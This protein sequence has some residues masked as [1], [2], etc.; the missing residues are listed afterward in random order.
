[1]LLVWR[2]VSQEV[3]LSAF[4]CHVAAAVLFVLGCLFLYWTFALARLRYVIDRNALTVHWG[5]VR[6]VVPM[7]KIERVITGQTTAAPQIAGVNWPG[8][9]VGSGSV[10]LIGESLF[11]SAHSGPGDLAYIV[12]PEQTYALSV[13]NA[14][15][16]RKAMEA[17]MR[18]GPEI[19]MRQV[20]RRSGLAAQPFWE[21]KL[22]KGLALLGVVLRDVRRDCHATRTCAEPRGL[23]AATCAWP[24]RASS[25]AALYGDRVLANLV[26]GP[27]QLGEDDRPPA[28]HRTCGLR[29][30]FV[31]ALIAVSQPTLGISQAMSQPSRNRRGTSESTLTM[32]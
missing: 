5:F 8:Y 21:D 24:I 30:V 29:G 6:Q 20:P 16:F 11:Y 12:T 9:H 10:E 26:L 7:D 23:F 18:E 1:V 3:S 13:P 31:A 32:L 17:R 22:A 15:A 2:G 19:V 14:E 27:P 25:D 28:F 4:V